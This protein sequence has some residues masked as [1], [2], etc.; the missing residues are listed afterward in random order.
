MNDVIELYYDPRKKVLI[1]VTAGTVAKWGYSTADSKEKRKEALEKA[2]RAEG[3][4][5]SVYRHLIAR[6]TQL[7]NISPKAYKVM[8]EDAAWIKETF[9]GTKW[10]PYP[11]SK[12]YEIAVDMIEGKVLPYAP[13]PIDYEFDA[14]VIVRLVPELKLIEVAV[15]VPQDIW[16]EIAKITTTYIPAPERPPERI[17]F[18]SWKGSKVN[19]FLD[20]AG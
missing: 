4:A 20:N 15:G 16:M 8:R 9:Y 18:R 14:P 10:W 2:I 1:P 19:V 13:E 12:S 5:L 3:S 7:K 11:K 6:A 17:I